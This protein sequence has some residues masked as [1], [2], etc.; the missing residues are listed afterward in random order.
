M[1]Y[2]REKD[3]QVLQTIHAFYVFYLHE[4][5][6]C[7]SRVTPYVAIGNNDKKL[8]LTFHVIIIIMVIFKCYFA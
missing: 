1:S 8:R 7:H 5:I 6:R 4:C 2:Y 3:N